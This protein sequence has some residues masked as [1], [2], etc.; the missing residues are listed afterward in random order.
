MNLK[1]YKHLST[2]QKIL[3]QV[4]VILEYENKFKD[5]GLSY[6]FF[7]I[8]STSFS[9]NTFLSNCSACLRITA[10]LK[11]RVSNWSM[12]FCKLSG[13]CSLKNIPVF[14]STTVSSAPHLPYAITGVPAACAAIGT[15]PKSSSGGKRKA[16]AL[17]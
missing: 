10:A 1:K 3:F 5:I 14:L 4:F 15:R 9:W 11:V 6:N 2:G 12:A 7:S 8:N 13:V 17:L 16:F